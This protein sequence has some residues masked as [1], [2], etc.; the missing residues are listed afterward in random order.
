MG[1]V[2]YLYRISHHFNYGKI[3]LFTEWNKQSQRFIL[4]NIKL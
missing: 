2:V 4:K 3:Q 1:N